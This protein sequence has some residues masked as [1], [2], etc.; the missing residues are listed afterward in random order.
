MPSQT[1]ITMPT[2][3]TR[4]RD[5]THM[6]SGLCLLLVAPPPHSPQDSLDTLPR[7]QLA[8]A[9]FAIGACAR[10]YMY[11]PRRP[12]SLARRR[13]FEN[14]PPPDRLRLDASL[15]GFR[16]WIFCHFSSHR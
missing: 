14:R 3:S 2:P 15:R 16:C 6:P 10:A 5:P 9:A 4:H 11:Y 13:G 1:I 8:K 7:D 12:H